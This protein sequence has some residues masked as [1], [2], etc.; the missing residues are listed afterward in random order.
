MLYRVGDFFQSVA[1]FFRQ[2]FYGF[3]HGYGRC[4]GGIGGKKDAVSRTGDKCH[5]AD[6]DNNT[7]RHTDACGDGHN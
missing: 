7:K 6:Y 2:G 4:V 3:A 1:V 5:K